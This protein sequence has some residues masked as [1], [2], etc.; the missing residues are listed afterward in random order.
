MF[1]SEI[2]RERKTESACRASRTPDGSIN[3]EL[4]PEAVALTLKHAKDYLFGVQHKDFHWCAE[5]ESNVTITAEYVF[6]CQALGLTPEGAKRD[7]I[8]RFLLSARRKTE[9]G[10]SPIFMTAMFQRR[11][12]LISR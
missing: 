2:L 4:L 10:A 1:E 5:L 6:M 7:S 11:P 8:V 12:K 9:A 3:D